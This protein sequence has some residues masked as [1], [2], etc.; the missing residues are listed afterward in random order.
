MPIGISQSLRVAN[1][2]GG[3]KSFEKLLKL[4]NNQESKS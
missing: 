4:T 2:K 1:V 3:K